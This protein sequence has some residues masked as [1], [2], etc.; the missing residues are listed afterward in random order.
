MSNEPPL[1]SD[2]EPKKLILPPPPDTPFTPIPDTAD[3]DAMQTLV[4]PYAAHNNYQAAAPSRS[5]P[6]SGTSKQQQR[7]PAYRF[8]LIGIMLLIIA[9]LVATI[10]LSN[11]FIHLPM[12]F[13][14]SQSGTPQSSTGASTQGTVD[15]NPSFPTPGGGHGS[16]QTSQ[17]PASGTPTIL[18]T[19]IPS[20]TTTPTPAS[21]PT[22]TSTPAPTPTPGQN[23][24][25]TV[26]I[27][28]PPTAAANSSTIFINVS[29]NQPAVTVQLFVLYNAPPYRYFSSQQITDSSG[30]ASLPWAIHVI[31]HGL[32]VTASLSVVAR[33]QNGQ[34]VISPTVFVQIV[35]TV[36]G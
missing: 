9:G 4:V 36:G 16:T 26:Q 13:G 21:S 6:L 28:G 1:P 8:L 14:A 32:P 27:V 18:P 22:P 17:P 24:T 23:G 11:T 15:T 29:T 12:L 10:L 2:E 31:A 19:S 3:P 34:Q 25:L 33:N 35:G 20:P 30:N 5:A 7:D